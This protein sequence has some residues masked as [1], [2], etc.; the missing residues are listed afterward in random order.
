MT[1][2]D[3]T[4]ESAARV[5]AADDLANGE[6]NLSQFDSVVRSYEKWIATLDEAI[7]RDGGE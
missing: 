2:F 4:N 6:I 1:A 7:V 5:L 3:P